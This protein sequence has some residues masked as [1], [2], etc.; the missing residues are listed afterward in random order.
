MRHR[1]Q[2]SYAWC[3]CSG[4]VCLVL[5]QRTSM[6]GV[7]TADQYIWCW[8]SGPVCLAT[9]SFVNLSSA[10]RK[11]FPVFCNCYVHSCALLSSSCAF[12]FPHCVRHGHAFWRIS[13]THASTCPHLRVSSRSTCKIVDREF[14]GGIWCCYVSR[15]KCCYVSRYLMLLC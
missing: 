14:D 10:L 6:S 3:W 13:W 12:T 11:Y 5:M 1:L 9:H 4:P 7:D 15:Y 8:N 2:H